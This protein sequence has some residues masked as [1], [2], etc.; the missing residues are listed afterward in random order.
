MRH[1]G[2]SHTKQEHQEMMTKERATYWATKYKEL[3]DGFSSEIEASGDDGI[4]FSGVLRIETDG[5][6]TGVVSRMIVEASLE[7]VNNLL[8]HAAVEIGDLGAML[9]KPQEQ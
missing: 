8:A 9:N 3:I 4:A 5:M 2:G 6:Y 7:L 1:S